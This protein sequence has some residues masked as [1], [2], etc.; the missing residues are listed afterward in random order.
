MDDAEDANP[1][2]LLA[3]ISAVEDGWRIERG[4]EGLG[5]LLPRR[6]RRVLPNQA[7]ADDYLRAEFCERVRRRGKGK[8]RGR[9]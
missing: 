4:L 1:D 9:G 8:R 5:R 3:Q 6:A 2:N 7:E